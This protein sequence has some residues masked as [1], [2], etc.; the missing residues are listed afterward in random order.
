M[1]NVFITLRL[2]LS[3]EASNGAGWYV[4]AVADANPVIEPTYIETDAA[5]ALAGAF[6]TALQT[7]DGELPQITPPHLVQSGNAL[8]TTTLQKQLEYAEEQAAKVA[9]LRRRLGIIP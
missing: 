2:D 9:K 6:L 3:N 8:I 4:Q 7:T 1:E 5:S